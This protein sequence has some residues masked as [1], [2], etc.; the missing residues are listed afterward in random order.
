M[1]AIR[2]ERRFLLVCCGQPTR[3]YRR[4]LQALVSNVRRGC[5]IS[6]CQGRLE[7]EKPMLADIGLQL[8]LERWSPRCQ[9]CNSA[10]PNI[11]PGD[12]VQILRHRELAGAMGI[13]QEVRGGKTLI[14]KTL[15]HGRE[16][17]GELLLDNVR[18]LSAVKDL[19]RCSGCKLVYFCSRSCQ[20]QGWHAHR[21]FCTGSAQPKAG[22]F[23]EESWMPERAALHELRAKF[24]NPEARQLAST[25]DLLSAFRRFQHFI[26]KWMQAGRLPHL[27][28]GHYAIQEALLVAIPIGSLLLWKSAAMPP[29]VKSE[30]FERLVK[31]VSMH[32]QHVQMLVPRFH[33]AYWTALHYVLGLL[34]LGDFIDALQNCSAVSL[35]P[36][37]T[38]FESC[39]DVAEI[40]DADAA[41]SYKSMMS[42]RQAQ[43]ASGSRAFQNL[44]A[45]PSKLAAFYSIDPELPLKQKMAQ[46]AEI[47][48]SSKPAESH[49]SHSSLPM[50]AWK[51]QLGP[52]AGASHDASASTCRLDTLD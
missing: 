17:E 31:M 28:P 27:A 43:S 3:V 13:T 35:V 42:H 10:A 33:I 2:S 47:L 20:R 14:L 26:D 5:S 49:S 41:E 23:S 11:R 16:H 7:A 25:Q 22:Q 9:A 37:T 34:L 1:R 48:Q 38:L 24:D 32:V 30:I 39:L 15:L 4:H 6:E 45:D 44:T 40:F 52:Q 12:A 19:H 21:R 51:K 36:L 29:E 46:M 8:S 50:P 18:S